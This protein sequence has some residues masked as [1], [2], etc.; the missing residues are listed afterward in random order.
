MIRRFAVR[1]LLVAGFI[2]WALA[3]ALVAVTTRLALLGDQLAP[4]HHGRVGNCWIY[5]LVQ[6]HRNGGYL[7]TRHARD[8]KLF[9]RWAIPHAIVFAKLP[10]DTNL[11]FFSPAE[12][13]RKEGGLLPL[14]TIWFEGK[15]YRSEEVSA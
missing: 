7:S 5:A 9:N 11:E 6:Y 3:W 12:V 13:E 2:T 15:I 8:V 10:D 14:H 1:A 4:E